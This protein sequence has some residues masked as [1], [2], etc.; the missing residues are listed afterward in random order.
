LIPR[1]TVGKGVTGAVRYALG[2]GRGASNDNLEPGEK[3][4]VE[5]IGGTGFGFPI[6]TAGDADLARRIMEFDALNQSSRT[7]Q[8]E[9]DAFH[10]SLSWNPGET[11]GRA[12]M[13]EAAMGAL[14]SIGMANAKAVFACHNDM[15]YAHLH[16]VASKINPD[17]GRAYD[18]K[19]NFLKLS[20]W[21][22]GWER[23]H[24]GVV[25]LQREGAN[26]LRAAI[27]NRDASAV[28]GA[29]TEQRATFTAADLERSLAKQI[30]NELARGEFAAEILSHPSIV[31]LRDRPGGDV[32]RFTTRTVLEGEAQVLRAATGLARNERHAID[33]ALR[34][35]V[36]DR[37]EFS[38]IS[39]EQRAAVDHTTGA[40]GLALIDGQAGTG[41]SYTVNAIRE[42]YTQS[43]YQVIGLAPT[44][45]LA[46]D[47]R[48]NGF[49]HAATIHSE[50]FRLNSGRTSWNDRTLIILDEAAMVD[51]KLMAQVTGHAHAA[52]AKLILVGD[53]R[54]LSSIDRGGMF[55]VLK[56]RQGA[57]ELSEVRRQ[58]KND[59]RRAAELMA[60]GNFH[61]ALGMYDVKGAIHWER[62]QD[63]ARAALVAQWT[64]DTAANPS[65]SRFVF[66]YTNADVERINADLRAVRRGRGELQGAD[67]RL[68]TRHGAADFAVGDRIQITGT[69]KKLGLV[70]GA[71]GTIERI[72]GVR[73]AARLDGRAGKLVEFSAGE[74]PDFRHGY[75]GTIYKGQGKSLDQT[76]LYHSE[77]W[78]SAASY[79][80]LTRHRDKA[81]LFVGRDVAADVKQ[82]GRQMARVDNRRAA[83]H[84][85]RVEMSGPQEW[86][87]VGVPG[88]A[89]ISLA[90]SLTINADDDNGKRGQS[91][92]QTHH[93]QGEAL[94]HNRRH[95]MAAATA[96][97]V[98]DMKIGVPSEEA[99]LRQ[100]DIE[101]ERLRALQDQEERAQAFRRAKQIEFEE[102]Q[103]KQPEN[104]READAQDGDISSAQARYAIALGEN[105]SIRDPYGSL[106]RAAMS[107]YAMFHRNQEKMRREMA[108]ERDPEKRQAIDLRRN[109]E[110]CDYMALTSERLAGITVAITGRKDAPQ[111][112]LDQ[113]RA[114]DYRAQAAALRAERTEFIE[115]I[116]NRGQIPAVT[117]SAEPLSGATQNA[118][119]ASAD[120]ESQTPKPM[121]GQVA[122]ADV[123]EREPPPATASPAPEAST[124]E[125]S[126]AEIA[127]ATESPATPSGQIPSPELTREPAAGPSSEPE[128][129][130]PS[131]APFTISPGLSRPDI[132][133]PL[134]ASHVTIAKDALDR[135]AETAPSSPSELKQSETPW[136][137][138]LRRRV[139]EG[140]PTLRDAP[141]EQTVIRLAK[142]LQQDKAPSE[143]AND[144]ALDDPGP[145]PDM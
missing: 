58:S 114:A 69:D 102:A 139:E 24:G 143:A 119:A 89:P 22:Q 47:M 62:H 103:K 71:A 25:C 29:L 126:T 14:A 21:A 138:A 49:S 75:A 98:A 64:K 18:L 79:V 41:K 56:D 20:A 68:T 108:E 3:S 42:I 59:D 137:E 72:E 140:S 38:G 121:P 35:A 130:A 112:V 124:P 115:G 90:T 45:A 104:K 88:S 44:N 111:A 27:D 110:A 8:C 34:E 91:L 12:E 19:G 94:A 15:P 135:P 23:D 11:P 46:E 33:P 84:Y 131:A 61:T 10:L 26:A 92:S 127:E 100:A 78:R 125:V 31:P 30:P 39:G 55:G 17:T 141:S 80:A 99:L 85:H 95:D 73:I 2:E 40:T 1:A 128:T 77:H 13:E 48:S 118:E 93:T 63:A 144:Q 51:T 129:I 65:K 109:I 122:P 5:W 37:A 142:R 7:K 134:P 67:H 60:S 113:E 53:D 123:A 9:K 76:Y 145:E 82:L 105:Y 50:L 54:Q 133:A 57:A 83:S 81:E 66:A 97:R 96:S 117:P 70:N 52:G 86:P 87:Q 106:A 28:L 16:I 132:I 136:M 36:L 6:R 101:A 74:F 32:T 43:R 4:R 120:Q 107:E 116:Q